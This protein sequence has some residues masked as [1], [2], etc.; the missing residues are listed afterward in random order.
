[1]LLSAGLPLPTDVLV[2]D[3]LT[4]DGRK[5]SKSAGA[6]VDPLELVHDYGTD[7][8]RWWLLR[9]VPR[10]GDVDFTLERLVARADS[11]LAGGLGNLVA[12]VVTMVHRFRAGVVPAAVPAG[13]SGAAV[14]RTAHGSVPG[15]APDR[16]PGGRIADVCGR[17]PGL[18]DAALE[19]F[20]FRRAALAVWSVVDEANRHVDRTRPWELA[21]AERAGDPEA[22]RRLDRALAELVAA[23]AV[24]ATEL[25]PF[26]P[27]AAALVRERCTPVGGV[28]PP[29]GRLFPRVGEWTGH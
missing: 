19:A 15:G 6:T 1:M 17:A 23:C 10:A 16:E 7:A 8:V 13:G 2:H 27:G 4:V 28:L 22:G 11:D 24:V 26:L 3:C 5:I 18:V 21:A 12:R 14:P 20:D 25:E 29:A 9:E